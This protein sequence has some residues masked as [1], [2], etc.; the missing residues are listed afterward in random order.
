MSNH[1]WNIEISY[2]KYQFDG[3]IKKI[4]YFTH[5]DSK[6]EAL[7]VLNKIDDERIKSLT[8]KHYIYKIY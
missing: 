1:R 8:W 2:Y 4:R 5:S 7:K 3:T 6:K